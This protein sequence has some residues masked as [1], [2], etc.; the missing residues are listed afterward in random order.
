MR[1]L[2]G[3]FCVRNNKKSLFLDFLT[4]QTAAKKQTHFKIVSL[5]LFNTQIHTQ[6]TK[7]RMKK[8]MRNKKKPEKS[9]LSAFPSFFNRAYTPR[10]FYI[11]TYTWS[12]SDKQ[13]Q[14]H[15]ERLKESPRETQT[16]RIRDLNI[17]MH[18][19]YKNKRYTRLKISKNQEY[20]K[21][22]WDSDQVGSN[23]SYKKLIY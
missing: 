7:I 3:Q 12:H 21:N 18:V 23:T 16:N 4:T 20:S 11:N 2:Q 9:S 19:F 22:I 5:F 13:N 1:L 8:L 10:I 17:Y 6:T 14:R 15:T